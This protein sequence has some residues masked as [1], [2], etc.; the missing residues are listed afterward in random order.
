LI[1]PDMPQLDMHFAVDDMF[2]VY[3]N[4]NMTKAFMNKKEWSKG[5]ALY[6]AL[7]LEKGWNHI[8]V[9][10]GQ[11]LDEWK[12][13]IWLTSTKPEFLKELKSAVDK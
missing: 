6:E 10:S 5:E 11:T 9:V 1:E 2:A 4:G 13:K 12:T 3:V 7:P 8:L